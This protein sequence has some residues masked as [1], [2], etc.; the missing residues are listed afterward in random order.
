MGLLFT[1]IGVLSVIIQAGMIGRLVN[2]FGDAMVITAGIVISVI[3]F[4]LLMAAPNA[5]FIIVY[6]GIFTAGNS[7]LRPSIS[8][9]VTKTAREE[10]QGSAVGIMQS[11]DSLGRILGP[12][13]GGIV[14]DFNINFPYLLGIMVLI[15]VLLFFKRHQA[16]F[17]MESRA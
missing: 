8:T 3:G 4:L 5:A 11:F 16:N 1:V 17:S 10:E 2:R 14:F 15:A 9:L 7:L 12:V 13:T 6:A